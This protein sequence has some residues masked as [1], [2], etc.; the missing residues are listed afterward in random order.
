MLIALHVP[1]KMVA[2][3]TGKQK[4]IHGPAVY[5]SSKVDCVCEVPSRLPSECE[6]VPLYRDHY[7]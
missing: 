6:L 7:L 2:L 3:P 5:V 4:C 1:M